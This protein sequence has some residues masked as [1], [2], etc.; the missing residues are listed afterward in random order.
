V[1]RGQVVAVLPAA[2]ARARFAAAEHIER[3]THVLLPGFVNAHTRAAMTLL[4]GAAESSSFDYWLNSQVRPLE[5][6]WMDA[7]Y[8]RDGT[9][10]AIADMLTSGTTCFAD[11]HLFPKSWRRRRRKQRSAPALACRWPIR[12][13][14]GPAPPTNASR[15]GSPC[16]MSIATIR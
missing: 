3:P 2:Q 6:R 11:M 9:E 14:R 1:H 10:L 13:T 16:T 5:Q 12:R 7:E 15:R 4:R 8:A